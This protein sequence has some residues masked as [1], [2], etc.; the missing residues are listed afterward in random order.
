MA[1]LLPIKAFVEPNHA[2]CGVTIAVT[3]LVL[4]PSVCFLFRYY[5]AALK[6]ACAQGN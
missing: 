3:P 6:V 1:L 2:T 5:F 4:I